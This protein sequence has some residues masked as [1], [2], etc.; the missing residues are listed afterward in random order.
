MINYFG[1]K[2]LLTLLAICV[3]AVVCI[4]AENPQELFRQARLYETGNDSIPKD[5]SKSMTLY[6]KAAAADYA[7]AMNYV[8]FRY[9]TGAGVK[10]DVDSALFWIRKAALTGDITAAA[11]LGYLLTE[12]DSVTHDDTEALDW[13]AIAADGGVP[14]AQ[15]ELVGLA[16]KMSSP[17]AYALLG[18][19]YSKGMGVP[20]DH[21]KA[22]ENY[23]K[24][25]DAGNPSAQFIIAELLDFFPDSLEFKE[26][27]Q[28]SGNKNGGN[29]E[30]EKEEASS[31]TETADYWYEKAAR[32][33]V[34][35]SESAYKALYSIPDYSISSD[36]GPDKDSNAENH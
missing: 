32:A 4:N 2:K 9:Y 12:G 27:T 16:S 18:E 26:I 8:G 31:L 3:F 7:P 35:D 30:I 21:Q 17:K 13:L 19:A 6:L 36:I 28:E 34:T 20:Y 1:L 29:E 24:A 11:N 14:Q 5:E 25:A 22:V 10:H 33:G 23:K 15:I